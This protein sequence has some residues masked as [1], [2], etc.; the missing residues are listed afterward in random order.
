MHLS[1]EAFVIHQKKYRDY[2][3]L[4]TLLT[5]NHGLIMAK[6]RGVRRITAKRLSHFEPINLLKIGLF[7]RGEYYTITESQLQESFSELKLN[8]KNTFIILSLSEIIYKSLPQNHP[9]LASVFNLLQNHLI[10]LAKYPAKKLLLYQS[11]KIKLLSLLGFIGDLKQCRYCSSD[12]KISTTESI[13]FHYEQNG[14]I[15]HRCEINPPCI[16]KIRAATLKLIL[17]LSQKTLSE[18]IK[19]QYHP[20]ELQEIEEVSQKMIEYHLQQKILAPSYF[21]ATSKTP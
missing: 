2:D 7:K 14:V 20:Q 8:A 6:G 1:C 15:C 10:N 4:I 19:I 17:F 3:S 21:T 5:A 16:Q 12:L 9:F 13:K 18:I 11:F